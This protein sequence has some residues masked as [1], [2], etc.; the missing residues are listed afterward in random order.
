[1]TKNCINC[2]SMFKVSTSN[3]YNASRHVCC[4]WRCSLRVCARRLYAKNRVEICKRKREKEAARPR[5]P[6]AILRKICHHCG[7]IYTTVERCQRYCS[8]RCNYASSR[9]RKTLGVF[10]GFKDLRVGHAYPVRY[11]RQAFCSECNAEFCANHHEKRC[12]AACYNKSKYPKK[13]IK[14]AANRERLSDTYV[15]SLL[16]KR[17]DR[18]TRFPDEIVSLHRVNIQLKRLIKTRKKQHDIHTPTNRPSHHGHAAGRAEEA[19]QQ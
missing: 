8:N 2:G 14:Q 16:S 18:Y 13:R 15:C 12:S 5:Q 6:R 7:S 1:M 19:S 11:G 10:N 4:S 9:K 3:S 17:L